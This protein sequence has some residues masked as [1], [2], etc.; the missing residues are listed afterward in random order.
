MKDVPKRP[1]RSGPNEAVYRKNRAY[2][3]RTQD[4]CGICGQPI[5]NELKYPDPM[6]KSLDHIV[7]INL[8]GH[9]FDRANMQAAHLMCNLQKGQRL[10]ARQA[11]AEPASPK[12]HDNRDL[13]Q[14]RE[15][16]FF[17]PKE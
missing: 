5:D 11:T 9:P 2:V 13:P 3:L 1:D 8:G 10:Q 15:W 14:S 12:P 17:R 7:P 4:I 16:R 6:S